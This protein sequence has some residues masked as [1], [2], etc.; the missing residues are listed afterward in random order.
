MDLARMAAMD[1]YSTWRVDMLHN[2]S[3]PSATLIRSV[4]NAF[5]KMC[6]RAKFDLELLEDIRSSIRVPL[7]V[8]EAIASLG[9][10]L[11]DVSVDV[12]SLGTGEPGTLLP[13]L[14]KCTSSLTE[15]TFSSSYVDID[16]S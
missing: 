3:L 7:D 5:R 1:A 10:A 2:Q 13:V 6:R 9:I 14:L 15:L 4:L 8:L 12:D 16:G 11:N